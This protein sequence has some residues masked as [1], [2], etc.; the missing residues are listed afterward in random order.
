MQNLMHRVGAAALA[1]Y[2]MNSGTAAAERPFLDLPPQTTEERVVHDSE[3][4]EVTI[5]RVRTHERPQDK[6]RNLEGRHDYSK[7]PRECTTAS[8]RLK[9]DLVDFNEVLRET[10]PG[11]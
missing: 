7:S 11:E 10:G 5:K 6:Q 9:Y 1:S 8:D 3:G 4:R 2:L